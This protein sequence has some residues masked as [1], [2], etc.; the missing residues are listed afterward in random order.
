MIIKKIQS[1]LMFVLV[2]FALASCGVKGD[3]TNDSN[4]GKKKNVP[5]K[6]ETHNS[7][8]DSNDWVK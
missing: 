6:T 3:L 1:V 4:N 8:E 2:T 7:S 5:V